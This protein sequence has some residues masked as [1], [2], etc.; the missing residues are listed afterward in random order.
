MNPKKTAIADIAQMSDLF[1]KLVLTSPAG[2]PLSFTGEIDICDSAEVYWDTFK[3]RV[4]APANYPYGIPL[5]REMGSRIERIPDRHISADGFCCVAID[6]VLLHHAAKRL[7]VTVFVQQ[8][9]YPYLANQLYFE[10]KRCYAGQEYLH[11]F[12]GVEQ[13]YRETMNSPDA[14]TAIKLLECV[15]LRKL[16]SRNNPC[17]C[18]SSKKFK[19]CHLMAS[20]YLSRISHR[21]LQEDLDSFQ[22]KGP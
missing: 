4:E 19:Y 20:E 18:G 3:I 12:D 16:P 15:L 8:Y 11:A 5:V 13:F 6:H 21:R 10:S 22:N 14:D 17:F 1:P 7:T 2:H 9:V